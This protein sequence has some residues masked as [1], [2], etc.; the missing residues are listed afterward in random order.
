MAGA[1]NKDAQDKTAQEKSWREKTWS[2]LSLKTLPGEC[3]TLAIGAFGGLL[4]TY[5]H[6]PGGAMS[7]S[8]IA[9]ALTT[10]YG[11]PTP[12]AGPLRVL[13]LSTMGMA[14]GAVVG[15]DTFANMAAYPGSM[16]LMTLCVILMTL[17]STAVWIYVMGWPPAMALLSSV[18]G[19]MS[20]ILSVSMS[21][22]A[23]AAKVAV[24]QMSRVIFLVTVL[25]FIVVWESGDQHATLA[26]VP[27]DTIKVIAPTL[28][29]GI[30]TG[31]VFTRLGMG[32]GFLFGAL[33]ASGVIH[34]LGYGEG[35]APGWVL[36][37]GQ[38]LLG[39]W[40]GTRF[41]GFD[42]RLFGKIF[43]GTTAS[44]GAAMGVSVI[45]AMGVSAFFGVSFGTTLMAYAPGG[46]DA[47]M[48]LALSLGVDPIF[49]S[50]HHLARYFFINLTLPFIVARMQR[51]GGADKSEDAA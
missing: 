5:L 14:I 3:L 47:M 38:I 13:A 6:I 15:P 18:P 40:V 45:F 27:V 16:A 43:L 7:G 44:V 46:Q 17:A 33:V 24:V 30:L 10:V 9:V 21:L 37:V 22:G 28:A 36:F 51:A 26:Q 49:V 50:A 35:R 2:W 25:P 42:W 4:F 31:A 1:Q 20:Y 19:S 11:K 32:G 8:V 23:D 29:V 34:Y 48:I 12:L 41:V 39:S